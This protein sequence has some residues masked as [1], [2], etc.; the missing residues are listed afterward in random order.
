MILRTGGTGIIAYTM[1]LLLP[2]LMD[3]ILHYLGEDAVN[4]EVDAYMHGYIVV[5]LGSSATIIAFSV[6]AVSLQLQAQ[7]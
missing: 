5:T 3:Y 2:S 6:R 4:A 7:L 1:A